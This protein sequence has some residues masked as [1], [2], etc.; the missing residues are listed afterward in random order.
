MKQKGFTYIEMSLLISMIAL[1]Y[2]AERF[3]GLLG[4]V[5]LNVL[6][7]VAVTFVLLGVSAFSA[8]YY[9]VRKA[10]VESKSSAHSV[11]APK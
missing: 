9:Q 10:Q 11:S 4:D 7:G 2:L 8:W 3:F 1:L 5:Q 6:D